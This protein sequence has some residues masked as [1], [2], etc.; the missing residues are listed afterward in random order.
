MKRLMLSLLLL[1]L[2]VPAVAE[3]RPHIVLVMADDHGYGDTGF[4]GH[5]FVKTP[6]LDAMA[7]AGV[8]FNRFYSSAPVCSPTRASVMTGRHS[9]RVNV[10]NHGHYLRP[11]ETTVA[12]TL[13]SA[14]YVTGHFGKWH[15]N[16][17]RGPGVPIID[18]YPNG[19]KD[20]GFQKWVSVTNFFDLNPIM[21]Q[22]GVFKDFK[23]D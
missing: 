9:F 4:T 23:G 8:V 2:S 7:K 13:G 21:S 10:P 20:F 19:P 1:G 16:G 15:L 6:H 22:N 3:S 17:L 5:P 11:H 14:G 12:E 18:S